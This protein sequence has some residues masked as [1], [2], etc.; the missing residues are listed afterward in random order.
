MKRTN[1]TIYN[2]YINW[3]WKKDYKQTDYR[4]R[5]GKR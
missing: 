4:V 1:D 2:N 5:G 3:L